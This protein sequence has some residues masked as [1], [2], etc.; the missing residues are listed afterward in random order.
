VVKKQLG[1]AELSVEAFADIP[2]NNA[3][4]KNIRYRQTLITFF[5]ISS[6]EPD[7]TFYRRSTNHSRRHY[8]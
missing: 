6:H 2:A 3:K 5:M 1:P 7:A 8:H 4:S